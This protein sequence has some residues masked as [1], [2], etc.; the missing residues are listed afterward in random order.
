MSN[1]LIDDAISRMKR[2][3]I[4]GRLNRRSFLEGATVLIEEGNIAAVGVD[5]GVLGRQPV[6]D[7]PHRRIGGFVGNTGLEPTDDAEHQTGAP[8][9]GPVSSFDGKDRRVGVK[10]RPNQVR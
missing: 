6:A 10:R 3:L 7:Y 1:R 2:D 9:L 4:E 8:V 5:V